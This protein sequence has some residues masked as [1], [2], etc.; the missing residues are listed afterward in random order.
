MIPKSGSAR[1]IE[2]FAKQTDV[3]PVTFWVIH[4][5]K[6]VWSGDLKKACGHLEIST[7]DFKKIANSL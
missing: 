1:R 4:E 2:L 6:R 7:K 5:D 3:I